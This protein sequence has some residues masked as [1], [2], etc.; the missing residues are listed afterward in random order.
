MEYIEIEKAELPQRFSIDLAEETFVLEIFYNESFD[1]FSCNLYEPNDLE[2]E[3]PLIMGEKLILNQPLWYDFTSL[4]LPAPTI[5][6]MDLAN[7]EKR[8]TWENMNET[9]FLY[10]LNEGDKD[11]S[12]L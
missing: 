6:P 3:T 12:E 8:I 5:V 9:V 7:K 10:L 1:F 4:N 11:E 2:G